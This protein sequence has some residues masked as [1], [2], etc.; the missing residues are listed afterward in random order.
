SSLIAISICADAP[1][2]SAG[3][4][5][6][7]AVSTRRYQRSQTPLGPA[8]IRSLASYG[9]N[10]PRAHGGNSVGAYEPPFSSISQSGCAMRGL[11][12]S[13]T[14]RSASALTA[15]QTSDGFVS[16]AEAQARAAKA[17]LPSSR[18]ATV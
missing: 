4:P 9:S 15:A 16:A 14:I 7:S 12:G 8:L 13:F 3:C 5:P 10:G 6:S 1:N 17:A 18:T 11:L 2:T